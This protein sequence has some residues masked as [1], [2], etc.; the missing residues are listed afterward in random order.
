MKANQ[1][2]FEDQ[3]AISIVSL[4]DAGMFSLAAYALGAPGYLVYITGAL[5]YQITFV[6]LVVVFLFKILEHK[7]LED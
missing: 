4:L 2:K 3:L 5:A 6:L 7:L 1:I